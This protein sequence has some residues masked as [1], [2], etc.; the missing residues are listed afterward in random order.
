MDPRLESLIARQLAREFKLEVY[1]LVDDRGPR[2]D[3]AYV[4][5][6]RRTAVSVELNVVE[7]F[8]RGSDRDF[9]RF[10]A[11]ARSSLAET[12]AQLTDG[13]DRGHYTADDVA[14]AFRLARRAVT[15]IMRLRRALLNRSSK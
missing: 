2:R 13:I 10:L 1:R 8:H 12:E 4:D 3:F 6:L 15:A 9:A 7:G 14:P 5:H 11:I